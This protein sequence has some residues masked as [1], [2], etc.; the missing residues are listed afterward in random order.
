MEAVVGIEDVLHACPWQPR[1]GRE[2]GVHERARRLQLTL[3]AEISYIRL[4]MQTSADDR[5]VVWEDWPVILP[6]HMD[7]WISSLQGG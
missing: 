6:H 5:D 1:D 7:A 2:Q 3:P 4:P